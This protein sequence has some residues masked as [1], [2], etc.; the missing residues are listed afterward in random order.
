M[1]WRFHGRAQVD[2]SSP[3]AF[4]VCQ[5]CGF[6]YN[7]RDLTFQFVW[8]GA[9]KVNTGLLVCE[10]CLDEP[11]EQLRTIVLPADPPSIMNARVEPYSL[12][13]TD[14]RITEDGSTLTTEAGDPRVRTSTDDES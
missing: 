3:R 13:E 5:R 10:G 7:V 12:D 4:G 8:A 14:Y 1:A 11:N 9:A 2:P 6:L